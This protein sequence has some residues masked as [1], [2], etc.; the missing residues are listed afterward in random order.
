MSDPIVVDNTPPA[1]GDLR[2]QQRGANVQVDLTAVDRT[3]VVAAMDYA[4]DSGRD[5][6]SVLPSDRIFDGPQEDVSFSVGGLSP[7]T[8]QVTLRAVDAKGNVDYSAWKARDEA[9]RVLRA[10]GPALR[11]PIEVRQEE[12]VTGR[13]NAS[14]SKR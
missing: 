12:R 6:Q 9:E 10:G 7:G 3:S 2:W 4:V 11:V 14:H 8:H 1:V 5:W 13:I